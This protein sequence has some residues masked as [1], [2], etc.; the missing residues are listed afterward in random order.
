MIKSFLVS[1]KRKQSCLKLINFFLNFD[2][3]NSRNLYQR[4]FWKN[5]KHFENIQSH[6][7]NHSILHLILSKSFKCTEL[8]NRIVA[9]IQMASAV[10]LHSCTCMFNVYICFQNDASYFAY[11]HILIFYL[12]FVQKFWM[13]K[14][15]KWHYGRQNYVD[16]WHF[17]ITSS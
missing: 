1:K 3:A 12:V 7:S 13:R 17:D 6:L 5:V 2:S 11:T 9:S 14:P 4:I 8:T 15:T 10:R 16:P